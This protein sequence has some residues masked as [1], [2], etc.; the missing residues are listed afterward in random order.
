MFG[1]FAENFG[2]NFPL[3]SQGGLFGATAPVPGV[4]GSEN[5][6]AGG[7]TGAPLNPSAAPAASPAAGIG[8]STPSPTSGSPLASPL[9][10]GQ[11]PQA[12][13]AAESAPAAGVASQFG[14]GK[15]AL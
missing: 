15:G 14:G 8:G 10:A 9:A 11:A 4:P 1:N 5:P 7:L 6:P 13:P 12:A 2:L 3:D